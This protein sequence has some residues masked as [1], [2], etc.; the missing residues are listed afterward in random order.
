[1]AGRELVYAG[2]CR[3]QFSTVPCS[4]EQVV[5]S[6]ARTERGTETAAIIL[7][8]QPNRIRTIEPQ[9]VSSSPL[10]SPTFSSELPIQQNGNTEHAFVMI[11][12]PNEPTGWATRM[13]RARGKAIQ[14]RISTV[15]T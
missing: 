8:V 7:P 13:W 2:N 3:V 1:M 4:V 10:P 9:R 5:F 6:S 12:I 11:N 15:I 14:G